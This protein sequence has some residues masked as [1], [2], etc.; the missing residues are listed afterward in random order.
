MTEEVKSPCIAVCAIDDL[1][2]FCHGCYRT[3]DE[4]RGWWDMTTDEQKRL[5]TQLEERQLQAVNFD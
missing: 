1:S 4:I 3:I 5:L 2:G